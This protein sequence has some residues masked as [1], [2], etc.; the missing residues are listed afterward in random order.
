MKKKE[1]SKQ[2]IT[3]LFIFTL[4]LT[5]NNHLQ[6]QNG[7]AQ[8]QMQEFFISAP[9]LINDIFGR[10]STQSY[11]IRPPNF[12]NTSDQRY[13][14]IYFLHGFSTN[15]EYFENTFASINFEDVIV[16]LPSGHHEIVGGTFWENSPI[17]GN[18]ED[19][20]IYDVVNFTDS[21]FRT[22]ADR[23]FRGVS[24]LSMGGYAAINIGIKHPD[25]FGSV[26]A[27]SPG[28]FDENGLEDT[29]MFTSTVQNFVADFFETSQDLSFFESLMHY[30]ETMAS[31]A[32]GD[33]RRFTLAYGS[34]FSPNRTLGC[35]FI[36]YPISNGGQLVRDDTYE[37]WYN[38]FGGIE[39]EIKQ[40]EESI[41]S[42][43]G[44]KIEYGEYDGYRWIPRGCRFLSD[45]LSKANLTHEIVET[46]L[47][48]ANS[49]KFRIET[50]MIPFFIETFQLPITEESETQTPMSQE[51]SSQTVEETS[52]EVS[53]QSSKVPKETSNYSMFL[54]VGLLI[55]I[56]IKLL[57]RQI[58]GR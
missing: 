6:I 38:G 51:E 23:D 50:H 11:I 30:D 57:K 24:G 21:N 43:N 2:L 54:I 13:P 17:T 48:H 27:I 1:N 5:S 4:L 33:I 52:I 10:S 26:Y 36:N 56:V 25:V 31:L 55:I 28:L 16:V 39:S 14:V 9:S 34:A 22:I 19:Y 47:G 12:Y 7:N 8:P 58:F 20:L 15:P 18:W 32:A 46:N 44:L 42:L 41:M 35:P 29:D 3:I 53:E 49:I 37:E 45:E 40:Y